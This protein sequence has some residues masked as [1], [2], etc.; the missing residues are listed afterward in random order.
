MAAEQQP[1]NF[2]EALD[3][4]GVALALVLAAMIVSKI[5]SHFQLI[6][7]GNGSKT[8]KCLTCGKMITAAGDSKL[9]HHVAQR[10]A[11]STD[12]AGNPGQCQGNGLSSALATKDLAI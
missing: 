3:E 4:A 7:T 11:L 9:K 1:V 8:W 12:C 2:E 5:I 10:K 6:K